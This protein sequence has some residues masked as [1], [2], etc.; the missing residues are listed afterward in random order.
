M[1]LTKIIRFLYLCAL[2]PKLYKQI[3][4][5]FVLFY[6][7]TIYFVCAAVFSLFYPK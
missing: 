2:I 3:N 1:L 7:I 6:R 5:A 4:N